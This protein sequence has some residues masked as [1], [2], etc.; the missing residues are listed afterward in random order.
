MHDLASHLS[1]DINFGYHTD[2]FFAIAV[3]IVFVFS[4]Y[5]M[6]KEKHVEVK[7]YDENGNKIPPPRYTRNDTRNGPWSY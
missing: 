6:L 7:M 5:F 4:L 3:V 1:T 2:P